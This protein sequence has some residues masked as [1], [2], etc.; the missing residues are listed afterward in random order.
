MNVALLLQALP[1]INILLPY[2]IPESWG[3]TY[4]H[5]HSAQKT[6]IT[7]FR[8]ISSLSALL[9]LKS[10]GM[11][12]FYNTPSSEY[13]HPTLL[14]PLNHDHRSTLDRSST[15]I[16]RLLGAIGEHPAVGAVGYD[17]LL[18]GFSIGLWTAIRSL[19][20]TN[21]LSASIPFVKRSTK[22]SPMK[23]AKDEPEE[24][25]IAVESYVTFFP[26]YNVNL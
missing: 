10:T 18:S 3:T 24:E 8:T 12:L 4:T 7:L 23:E 26:K 6:Y 13:Y 11:A 21:L 2:L 9:H 15:A 1:S 17:V 5:P 20:P 19:D 22:L 25:L 16:A 14:H